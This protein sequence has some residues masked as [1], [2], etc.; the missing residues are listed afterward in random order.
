LDAKNNEA[1]GTFKKL[2]IAHSLLL[3]Q[4]ILAIHGRLFPVDEL[5]FLSKLVECLYP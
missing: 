3:L 4:N 2:P 1:Q 5:Q